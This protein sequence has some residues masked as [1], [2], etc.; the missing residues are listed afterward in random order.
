[1]LWKSIRLESLISYP[2]NYLSSYEEER[3]RSDK[4]W[5][6]VIEKNKIYGLF[7]EGQMVSTVSLFHG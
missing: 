3:L 5:V 1:M 7:V 2:E 6:D 4:Q